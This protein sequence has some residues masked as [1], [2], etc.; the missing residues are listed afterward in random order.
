MKY[1]LLTAA[2]GI[3]LIASPALA[4]PVQASSHSN[5]AHSMSGA[6]FD[7]MTAFN[8]SQTAENRRGRYNDYDYGRSGY[9]D[10]YDNR[11]DYRRGDR[12]DRRADSR[13]TGRTWRGNDGRYYCER[14][15]GTTGLLIGGAAGAVIGNEVARR[16]DKTVGA[17]LGG[18]GGALLGRSIDKSSSRCR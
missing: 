16:G 8:M 4:A 9:N 7:V 10:R 11:R 17:I 18:L 1:S 6:S 3:A 12:Y 13:H 15:D 5:T 14:S 2:T